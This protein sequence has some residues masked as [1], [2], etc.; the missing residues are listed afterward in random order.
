MYATPGPLKNL[1]SKQQLIIS[2]WLC[3]ILIA[4]C[5]SIYRTNSEY[6]TPIRLVLHREKN[7]DLENFSRYFWQIPEKLR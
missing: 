2:E 5:P 6:S 1:A 4:S 7:K 3:I